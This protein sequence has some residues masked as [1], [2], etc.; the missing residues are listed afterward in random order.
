MTF[1]TILLA[2]LHVAHPPTISSVAEPAAAIA[3]VTDDRNLAAFL[4]AWGASETHFDDRLGRGECRAFECDAHRLADGTVIH[5]ARGYWQSHRNGMSEER[6]EA[7]LGPDRTREQ[8]R[9][10]AAHARW[11]LRNCGGDARCAFRVLGGLPRTK[12]LKGE[13]ARMSAYERALKELGS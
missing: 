1:K 6:W 10:A 5:R 4:V 12:P 8:A 11:A 13:N 7:M 3:E 2:I 9:V